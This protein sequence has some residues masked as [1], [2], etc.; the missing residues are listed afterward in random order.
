MRFCYL[1]GERDR[2]GQAVISLILYVAIVVRLTGVS[3]KVSGKVEKGDALAFLLF[4]EKGDALAFLL[5]E[6]KE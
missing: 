1:I 3:G 6:G 4:E 2:R 5:F